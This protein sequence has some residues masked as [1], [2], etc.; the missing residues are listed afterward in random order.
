MR[1][2]FALF[3]L[4]AVIGWIVISYL[5]ASVITLPV[6]SF[7]AELNQRFQGLLAGGFAIFLALQIWLVWTTVRNIQVAQRRSNSVVSELNL[8]LLRE[9]IWTALPIVMTIG[10][11]LA[12]YQ[13]W[14]SLAP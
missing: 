12:S 8:S 4:M 5:P 3:M 9:A 7:P 13:T 6:I 1:R 2:I 14:V 11:A 10:L